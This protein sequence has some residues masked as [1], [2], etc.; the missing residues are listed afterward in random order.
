M[1][2][3]KRRGRAAGPVMQIV[4]FG[5]STGCHGGDRTVVHIGGSVRF[6]EVEAQLHCVSGRMTQP[7]FRTPGMNPY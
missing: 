1:M 7:S 6:A 5:A 4:Q 3:S 2:A